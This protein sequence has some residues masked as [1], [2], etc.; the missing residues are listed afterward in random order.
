MVLVICRVPAPY[1]VKPNCG[2]VCKKLGAAP[3]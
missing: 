3:S 1:G 2:A